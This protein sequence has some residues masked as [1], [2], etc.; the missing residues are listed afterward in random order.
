MQSL[1]A[2]SIVLLLVT[3]SVFGLGYIYDDTY[4]PIPQGAQIV[5][6]TLPE[7]KFMPQRRFDPA[8]RHI[9]LGKRSTDEPRRISG[10]RSWAMIGLGKRR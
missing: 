10:E 5:V 1:I 8:W 2:S 9:G 6:E 4:F 7:T 3:N